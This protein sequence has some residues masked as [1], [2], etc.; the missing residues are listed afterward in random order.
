MDNIKKNVFISHHGKDDEHVLSLKE[1]L[2]ERGCQIRNSA[3]DS[4]KPNDLK[5][6]HEIKQHLRDQISWAGTFICLIGY[7]T[8]DRE[9]V[10]WEI[11]QA[12]MMGKKIIGVFAHGAAQDAE[13]PKGLELGSDDIVGWQFDK[14]I[15]ALENDAYYSEQPDGTPRPTLSNLSKDEC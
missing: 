13:I 7:E 15:D 3:P 5:E 10:E 2:A 8:Y 1:K 14:I 4:T 11:E 12:L 6:D 9:W